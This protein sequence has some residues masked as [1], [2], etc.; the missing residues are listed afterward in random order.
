MKGLD[1][2]P[3]FSIFYAQGTTNG[4]A[5]TGRGGL[6]TTTTYTNADGTARGGI[7]EY[8]YTVGV[9]ARF[10]SGPFSFDPS[11]FYQFGNRNVIAPAQRFADSGA[12]AGRSIPCGHKRVVSSTFGPA[13]SSVRCSSRGW[14]Y[15]PPVTRPGTTR[16]ATFAT[17]SRW[18]R[19]RAT[20]LTGARRS[21]RWVSTTSTPGSR[22]VAG[23]ATPGLPSAG[24][25]TAGYRSAP[26]PRTPSRRRLA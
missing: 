20:W 4:S 13:S 14:A 22:A 8:R 1:I 11:V 3:M 6:N 26:R 16:S 10:R 15:T 9:D 12:V 5:R 24:T 25:S 7:N 23:R 21:R 19:T 17:S 2:K 18:T